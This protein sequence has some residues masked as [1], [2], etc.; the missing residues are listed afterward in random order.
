M[1]DLVR[2][3]DPAAGAHDLRIGHASRCVHNARV[4]HT[5]ITPGDARH[6][7]G[8][9]H[10]YDARFVDGARAGLHVMVDKC[11]RSADHLLLDDATRRLLD[12]DV[13]RRTR[14]GAGA[15]LRNRMQLG[16][17]IRSRVAVLCIRNSIIVE[18]RFFINYWWHHYLHPRA[19]WQAVPGKL[20]AS[21]Q[22][23][24]TAWSTWTG[25]TARAARAT[26]ITLNCARHHYRMF[27]VLTKI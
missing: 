6:L 7:D 15:A 4:A 5:T 18:A 24:A 16:R 3:G 14:S 27:S 2:L 10:V 12:G 11:A 25:N 13:S 1:A 22:W 8:A 23:T 9:R 21:I 17:G 26:R 20:V 19:S